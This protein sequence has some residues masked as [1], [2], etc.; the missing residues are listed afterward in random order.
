MSVHEKCVCTMVTML[1]SRGWE[2]E[3]CVSL[4]KAVLQFQLLLCGFWDVNVA[5]S[6]QP[7]LIVLPQ[8]QLNK[9]ISKH[10]KTS[11]WIVCCRL[12]TAVNYGVKIH[13]VAASRT[14]QVSPGLD[15]IL[16][17]DVLSLKS[18]MSSWNTRIYVHEI[19]LLLT[20]WTGQSSSRSRIKALQPGRDT[21]M[22]FSDCRHG[23]EIEQW[24]RAVDQYGNVHHL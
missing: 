10:V 9:G 22:F 5:E 3:E 23:A 18:L 11:C 6:W 24:K 13:S 7:V 15:F 20:R 12:S 17:E 1:P 19:L 8:R 16:S 21:V 2:K 4:F 14:S